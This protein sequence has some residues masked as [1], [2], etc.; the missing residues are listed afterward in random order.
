MQ[1][2]VQDC[3]DFQNTLSVPDDLE[4]ALNEDNSVKILNF[5]DEINIVNN[6]L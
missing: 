3:P 6:N 2:L 4:E 1:H 5:L